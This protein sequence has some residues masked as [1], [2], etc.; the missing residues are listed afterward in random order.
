MSTEFSLNLGPISRTLRDGIGF[1]SLPIHEITTAL[2]EAR[3]QEEFIAWILH[4]TF[5]ALFD[6]RW[7]EE[8]R[9]RLQRSCA[10]H[11]PVGRYWYLDLKQADL[12]GEVV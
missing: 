2:L 3:N 5:K 7:D 6:F 12:S 4:D 8:V 1:A 9:E 10:E 11:R